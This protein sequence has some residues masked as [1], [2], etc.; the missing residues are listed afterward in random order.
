MS[1]LRRFRQMFPGGPLEEIRDDG[2]AASL[3]ARR[4]AEE[5]S[6]LLAGFAG[7]ATIRREAP[8]VPSPVP[9]MRPEEREAHSRGALETANPALSASLYRL[10]PTREEDER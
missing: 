7:G 1:I 4:Q 9:T 10:H 5:R 2:N 6:G 8:A 3:E